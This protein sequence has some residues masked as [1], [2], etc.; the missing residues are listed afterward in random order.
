MKTN[1]LKRITDLI[2]A[3]IDMYNR[4]SDAFES[5]IPA[6]R[7]IQNDILTPETIESFV[8]FAEECYNM[9]VSNEVSRSVW[10]PEQSIQ[11]PCQS[12]L[13]A[14]RSELTRN[15]RYRWKSICRQC[16]CCNYC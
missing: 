2:E 4:L 16:R 7:E 15:K 10:N 8:A 11:R 12:F 3:R 6:M 5:R 1:P 13:K 14:V 9:G